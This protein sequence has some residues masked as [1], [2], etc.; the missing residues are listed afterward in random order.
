MQCVD[1]LQ[2]Y[3]EVC[4]R[5]QTQ[6]SGSAKWHAAQ[7]HTDANVVS[8]CTVVFIKDWFVMK[9]LQETGDWREP[10]NCGQQHLY[11]QVYKSA[12]RAYTNVSSTTVSCRYCSSYA[13]FFRSTT[14]WLCSYRNMFSTS[15]AQLY[16]LTQQITKVLHRS[17]LSIYVPIICTVFNR[18]HQPIKQ[19]HRRSHITDPSHTTL[20]LR[21]IW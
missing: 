6:V 7:W 12:L 19:R 20:L 17:V 10:Q 21:S 3:E 14:A 8:W 9:G 1:K 4:G 13:C 5:L 2:R 11:R 16:G 15:Y 18:P